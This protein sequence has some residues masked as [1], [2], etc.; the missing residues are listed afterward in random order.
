MYRHREP[1]K[2]ETAMSKMNIRRIAEFLLPFKGRIGLI[3]VLVIISALLGIV[4]PIV[5]RGI[6]DGAIDG[7]NHGLLIALVVILIAVAVGAGL[8]GVLQ[9]YCNTTLSQGIMY[10]VKTLMYQRLHALSMRFYTDSRTGELMSRLTGDIAGIDNVVSGTLVSL[11]SN[12][13]VLVTTL[14]VMV[15]MSWQLTVI[16]VV[17]LPWLILPTITVGKI[18]RRMRAHRQEMNAEIQ[19]HMQESLGISGFVLIKT[20][21]R[22]KDEISRFNQENLDLMRL[23]IR[24]ALVGRWFFMLLAVVTAA[25]PALL[26]LYGGWQVISQTLSLGTV[27][28]FVALVNR[29]YNPAT[30]LMTLHVDIVTSAAYFERIFQY[31]DLTPDII[32]SIDAK[33][34]GKN[35]R[36]LEFRNVSFAYVPGREALQEIS[37]TVDQGQRIA[38]VG[39]S[40]AGKS[41]MVHLVPRLYDVSFGTIQVDDQDIRDISLNSLRGAIGMVT[42][43]TFLFHASIRDNLLFARPDASQKEL[44]DACR[45]AYI[46][47]VIKELPSGYETKVGERGYR[48]SGGEKQRIAIARVILKNPL[49][50]LLDEA[51]SSLDTYS[52]RYIQTALARLMEGRMTIAIAHRLSTIRA[53]DQILYLDK[54]KILERGT[55]DQL[56]DWNGAYANFYREQ[57]KPIDN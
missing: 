42:Q 24:E 44:E 50:F 28:A 10:N 41:S 38:L 2:S 52:E 8:V 26:Y 22:E 16:S 54:G 49:I 6:I 1:L 48:L 21:N 55:H 57:F 37:F 23:Q 17:V 20:F 43:E 47:D 4:P 19:A 15:V 29:L 53:A 36:K 33:N 11:V 25:G 46:H 35:I 40:G 27:I 14:T 7:S 9:G 39:P 18:R 30:S 45:A 51:T 34:I 12:V 32:D 3:L 13:V 31:L 5:I 56:L